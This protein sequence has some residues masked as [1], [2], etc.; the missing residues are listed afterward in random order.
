MGRMRYLLAIEFNLITRT[1]LNLSNQVKSIFCFLIG[2]GLLMSHMATAQRAMFGSNNNYVAPPS[3]P[4]LPVILTTAATA[5]IGTSATVGGT[6]TSDGGAAVTSRGLVWG[7]SPG[8]TTFSTTIGAGTG[9]FSTNLTGLS[10]ATT[11]YVR[12]YATN[13]I[14]T[15]YGNEISFNTSLKLHYDTNNSSSYPGTGTTLTDLSGNGNHGTILNSPSFTTLTVGGGVLAFNG[16]QQYIRTN[17]TPSNTCTISIWF[18]NTSNYTDINRGIFSTYSDSG[19]GNNGFYMGTWSNS[20]N[21][22]RDNNTGWGNTVLP[23]LSINTWYNVTV[24]SDSSGSGTIK[25]YLNGVLQT[26]IT[27]KTTHADVLN[28]GRTRFDA[29]Y[30]KGYIAK[31]MVYNAVLTGTDVLDNYNSQK[32][33]F[34]Y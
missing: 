21:L 2:V 30:W 6:V 9:T 24:T 13:S 11:Y 23:A 33:T 34:G 4:S 26:T 14:G 17:F 27:G 31:T 8:S 29:N 1:N 28:I 12:A 16:N 20:F 3:P 22:S 7:T 15:S 19:S 5:I 18:Y 10:L 25:V 32:A